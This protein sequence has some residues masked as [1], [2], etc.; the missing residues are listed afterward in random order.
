MNSFEMG[1]H[2]YISSA[3]RT[4][5]ICVKTEVCSQHGTLARVRAS[6]LVQRTK[7]LFEFDPV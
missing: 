2:K 4:T 5:I 1:E 3:V 7:L 6:V